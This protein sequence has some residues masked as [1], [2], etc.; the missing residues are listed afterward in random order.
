MLVD[1]LLS[2][3]VGGVFGLTVGTVV[4]VLIACPPIGKDDIL[5]RVSRGWDNG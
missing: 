3:E 5:W 4:E 1:L 2:R